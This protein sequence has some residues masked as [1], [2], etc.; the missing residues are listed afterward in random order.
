[1]LVGWPTSVITRYPFCSVQI[2]LW[3]SN[4]RGALDTYIQWRTTYTLTKV[5]RRLARLRCLRAE[6]PSIC[7]ISHELYPSKNCSQIWVWT[8]TTPLVRG[9]VT[10]HSSWLPNHGQFS[11][12]HDYFSR[13][14]HNTNV[15]LIWNRLAQLLYCIDVTCAKSTRTSSES[16]PTCMHDD[17]TM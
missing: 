13:S 9:G 15:Q 10:N 6:G 12:Y 5:T 2:H 8:S 1:M 17:V 16:T 4:S 14:H 3:N 7:W 11:L